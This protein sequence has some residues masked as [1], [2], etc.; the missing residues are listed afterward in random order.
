MRTVGGRAR[1]SC[2]AVL[3][4]SGALALPIAAATLAVIASDPGMR[5]VAGVVMLG[6]IAATILVAGASR[7]VATCSTVLIMSA[8]GIF[9]SELP[10]VVSAG[11]QRAIAAA[12]LMAFGFSIFGAA[13]HVARRRARTLT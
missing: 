10:S 7:L 11:S 2:A 13:R 1:N 3:R 9:L 4:V 5:G 6:A 12:A 8:A